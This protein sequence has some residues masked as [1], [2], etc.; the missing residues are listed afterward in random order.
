MSFRPGARRFRRS[1]LRV[2][3]G[4]LF[5]GL[6][7]LAL[8][9]AA[10]FEGR[11]RRDFIRKSSPAV[12]SRSWLARVSVAL[13]KGMVLPSFSKIA[14]VRRR[15][16][17]RASAP[18]TSSNSFRGEF[19]V[20]EQFAIEL[21]GGPHTILTQGA[22]DAQGELAL[23]GRGLAEALPDAGRGRAEIAN[24][25][26]FRDYPPGRR[27]GA[28]GRPCGTRCSRRSAASGRAAAAS[29]RPARCRTRANGRGRG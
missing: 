20:G 13:R 25:A 17:E 11:G 3:R 29:G 5:H 6:G 8:L 10:S 16:P 27:S 18:R 2:G 19:A 4:A 1:L 21:A 15:R 24:A 26:R 7:F 28:P 14:S 22:E 23:P 12:S 9:L